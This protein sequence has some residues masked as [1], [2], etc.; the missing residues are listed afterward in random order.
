MTHVVW[1]WSSEE[2]SS[3]I[4]PHAH[5]DK[6]AP[7][8]LHGDRP[9][10]LLQHESS[11]CAFHT[12]EH[13]GTSTLMIM[14]KCILASC[15]R[16]PI[17]HQSTHHKDCSQRT[18]EFQDSNLK[19]ALESYNEMVQSF[20]QLY[21]FNTDLYSHLAPLRGRRIPSLHAKGFG[22]RWV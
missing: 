9:G 6:R 3:L 17:P 20:H 21:S 2:L 18:I 10:L 14:A 4:M 5:C 16:L 13:T 11:G 15:W 12:L 1:T 22:V 8:W 19:P 7:G